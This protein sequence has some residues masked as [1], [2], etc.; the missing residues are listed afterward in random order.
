MAPQVGRGAIGRGVAWLRGVAR[1][2]FPDWHHVGRAHDP[3]VGARTRPDDGH[4]SLDQLLLAAADRRAQ[5][6]SQV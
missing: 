3:A 4:A 5:E 1:T 2:A 6:G